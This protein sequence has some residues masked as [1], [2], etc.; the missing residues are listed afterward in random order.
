[1]RSIVRR[2]TERPA[3]YDLG[4]AEEMRKVFPAAR[5]V[6]PPRIGLNSSRGTPEM[7]FASRTA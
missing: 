4:L 5:S 7:P 3:R 2:V 6:Q 1:M